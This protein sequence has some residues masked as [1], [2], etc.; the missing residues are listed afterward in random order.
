MKNH[1]RGLAMPL[2]DSL[3]PMTV[4]QRFPGYKIVPGKV[5]REF[6]ATDGSGLAPI[7]SYILKFDDQDR[8]SE[9]IGNKSLGSWNMNWV[10]EKKSFSEGRWVVGQVAVTNNEGGQIIKSNRK[11]NYTTTQGMGVLSEVIITVEHHGEKTVRTEESIEFKNYKINTGEG[12]RY[13][14]GDTPPAAKTA[15]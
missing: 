13:F 3:I 8:L 15:P 4:E 1:L 14:L 11:L 2:L 5:A 10:Y 7:T 6:I 12:M 9:V